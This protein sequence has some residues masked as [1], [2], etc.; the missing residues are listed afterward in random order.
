MAEEKPFEP[1]ASRLQKAK[2][3]GDVARSQELCSA[4]ALA[5][6]LIATALVAPALGAQAK[7]V[8][9]NAFA[10]A[11]P[12]GP[13][14]ASFGL[15]LVP[16]GAAGAAACVSAIAQG[17]GL[18]FTAVAFKPSR[19][20]PSENVKRMFSRE[21]VVS[22]MR[23]IVAFLCA[24]AAMTGVAGAVYATVL[25]GAGVLAVAQAAWHGV[26]QT[27]AAACAVGGVFAFADYGIQ[28]TRWRNRLKMSYEE[29]KRD[30]KEQDG[31][32]LA[33]GRRKTLHRR[34]ARGSL[35][36]VKDAAFVVT[37]PTH[38]AMALEYRPPEVPVPRVLI[39][40]ADEAAARVRERA[41]SL[42]IPLVENVA[43]ARALYASANAGDFIPQ[44]TYLA[45][46]EIVLRLQHVLRDRDTYA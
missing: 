42:G 41:F 18:H 33:R 10:G 16:A 21:S 12:A 40:A 43:L 28:F 23:A 5:G 11:N 25:H 34:I 19:L 8:L 2:R 13:L 36:R 22:S 14:A 27:C 32:P 35:A 15:M 3:E 4:A 20:N 46:A 26:L 37:N 38:I 6:G 24:G 45:V 17:G 31:D 1:T 30:Q 39:R 7:I 9:E 44:E 29:L